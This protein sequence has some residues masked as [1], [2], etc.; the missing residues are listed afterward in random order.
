[1]ANVDF[2]KR[3][4]DYSVFMPELNKIKSKIIMN[5]FLI[6]Y[7]FIIIRAKNKNRVKLEYKSKKYVYY[8]EHH[9]CPLYFGGSNDL[10]NLVLLTPYEHF[11]CHWLIP[12]FCKNRKDKNFMLYPLICMK[13][14]KEYSDKELLLAAKL[15]SQERKNISFAIST[16]KKGKRLSKERIEKMKISSKGSG[17]SMY[18]KKHKLKT[19][20]KMRNR[21]IKENN[22][23]Y[24]KK[25]SKESL[26]KR[27]KSIRI[28][29]GP[30]IKK[31]FKNFGL[32]Y[33]GQKLYKIVDKNNNEFWCYDL[34]GFCMDH[35][36][37]FK[38]IS[39]SIKNNRTYQG[40]DIKYV[41]GID[42]G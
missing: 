15:Y 19:I 27:V 16:N 20:D 13:N 11:L 9:I 4:K 1:M 24:G 3:Y 21:K 25:Y 10:I 38:M 31:I 37:S 29:R 5:K 40:Y 41:E 2:S 18:G 39:N 42:N 34:K 8:E 14:N 35:S 6:C 7:M 28:G 33:R 17:N 30:L 22:P 26:E 32:K 36:L 12:K 23:M